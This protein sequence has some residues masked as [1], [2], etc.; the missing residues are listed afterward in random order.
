[1]QQQKNVLAL[2]WRTPGPGQARTG[3]D[4]AARGGARACRNHT[5]GGITQPE[6]HTRQG[7]TTRRSACHGCF[8]HVGGTTEESINIVTSI[9]SRMGCVSV[10]GHTSIGCW[11]MEGAPGGRLAQLS[12]V[13]PRSRSGAELPDCTAEMR[14]FVSALDDALAA[15][16]NSIHAYNDVMR[17]YLPSRRC[18][19]D[20]VVSE[21]RKSKFF[22][23]AYDADWAYGIFFGNSRF[24]VSFGIK[25][26]GEIILPATRVRLDSIR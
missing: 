17:R 4:S 21:S 16:P 25:K 24:I 18:V 23:Q 1:M 2:F 12:D 22:Y 7:A 13:A 20:G 9:H 15:N 8:R 14:K 6:R 11:L 10:L 5:A 19:V 3:N 26:T